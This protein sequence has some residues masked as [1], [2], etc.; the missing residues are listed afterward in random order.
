M[1]RVSV[2]P[3]ALALVLA[4]GGCPDPR[5]ATQVTVVFEADRAVREVARDIEI[6]AWGADRGAAVPGGD[7]SAPQQLRLALQDIVNPDTGGS[8][9]VTHTLVPAD[10]DPTRLYRIEGRLYDESSADPI[11]VVRAISGYVE[12]HA[13]VLRLRF[14]AQCLYVD[15]CES[16]DSSC[17]QN[18]DCQPSRYPATGLPDQVDGGTADG[19]VEPACR[20]EL[21]CNDG[22]G[23]TDDVCFRGECIHQARNDLCTASTDSPVCDPMNGCQ[24]G[25]GCVET[26]AGA[27]C[28]PADCELARCE[29]DVCV[30]TALCRTGQSC[31]GGACV[32]CNDGD[33]CTTDA[34]DATAGAC[35]NTGGAGAACDD[36]LF[37]TAPGTCAADGSCTPGGDP[38]AGSTT[39]DEGMRACVG[40][41]SDADCPDDEVVGAC[42]SLEDAMPDQICMGA[43]TQTVM[44]TPYTCDASGSCVPG[45]TRISQQSCTVTVDTTRT[46]DT[47]DQMWFGCEGDPC[48]TEGTQSGTQHLWLCVS[49]SCTDTG[50]APST[51]MCMKPLDPSCFDAG[52]PDGSVDTG[53]GVDTGSGIDSGCGCRLDPECPSEISCRDGVDNDCDM[54]VDCADSDCLSSPACVF[55]SGMDSGFDSGIDSGIDSGMDSGFDSGIDSGIDSGGP[56]GS[57]ADIGLETS[58]GG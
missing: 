12:G 10:D 4:A 27:N 20:T 32:T 17:N 5:P 30:R 44:T 56:E 31:C 35:T 22:V 52:L 40:C 43:G 19:G 53:T 18:G 41:A 1:S 23:C 58:F 54:D 49:G 15:P 29:G 3:V 21:D 33:A 8:W 11:A 36:G 46:C 34:C 57:I 26:G 2:A 37:C 25:A 50:E 38:C 39:C 13:I 14:Y 7:G 45:P 55:D 47:T 51:R 6:L 24:Y 48:V 28:Q 9:P 42:G 16:P